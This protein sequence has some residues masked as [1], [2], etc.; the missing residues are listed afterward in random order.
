MDQRLREESIRNEVSL[1][2]AGSIRSSADVIKAIALGADAVYIGSAALIAIGCHMCQT[3]YT[4][5]CN[6]GIATQNED[7]VKRL[8]PDIAYERL[9]NLITGWKHEIAEMLGGMG[10]N[11]IESLKGNRLML[12]GVGL[13]EKELEILG[14]KHAGE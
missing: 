10:I 14:I 4:G 5:K 12:R 13:N 9:V 3:C 2:V 11:A 7:L 6:W 1:V 8:N